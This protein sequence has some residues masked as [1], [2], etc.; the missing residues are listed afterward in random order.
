M[1]EDVGSL[2]LSCPFCNSVA[3]SRA[4]GHMTCIRCGA[5]GPDADEPTDEAAIAAWNRRDGQH[6]RLP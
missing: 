6:D 3:L 1:S 2:P 5:E 4:G